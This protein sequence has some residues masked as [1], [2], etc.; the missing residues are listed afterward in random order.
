VFENAQSGRPVV[1]P[2]LP[3]DIDYSALA[4]EQLVEVA[5][6]AER[7]IAQ[8]HAVQSAA[9]VE[10]IRRFEAEAA[11]ARAAGRKPVPSNIEPWQEAASELGPACGWS[12][13]MAEHRV[14]LAEKL[15]RQLPGTLAA[16]HEGRIDL[17]RARAV[18]DATQGV[19]DETAAAVEQR[20]LPRAADQTTAQLRAALRRAVMAIDP[21]A[22]QRRH[23]DA[24]AKRRVEVRDLDDGI[25][26]LI[27]P[28]PADKAQAVYARV[29]DI[30]RQA[31]DNYRTAAGHLPD[32][33]AAR[34]AEPSLDSLRVDALL[35]LILG[36]PMPGITGS[37]TIGAPQPPPSPGRAHTGSEACGD[38][39]RRSDPSPR[40]SELPAGD[41]G[42]GR[43]CAHCG[44]TRPRPLLNLLMPLGTALGISDEPAELSGYGPIPA[45]LARQLAA[46]A[47]WRRIFT[48]P[49]S[50]TTTAAESKSYEPPASMAALVRARD[51]TCRFP[52]C[53]QPATRTDIDHR[54]PWP[55]GKTCPCN[56][57]CLCRFHH[58]LKTHH[59]WSYVLDPTSGTVTWLSPTRRAY[60]TNPES[61]PDGA[62]HPP[63]A[64]PE[65]PDLP[66][67]PQVG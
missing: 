4:P 57:C 54:L 42:C 40:T 17:N 31:L 49:V 50:G 23:D 63:P 55:H 44:C 9:A 8:A 5:A 58:Q 22:A 18:A 33:K 61:V 48:D 41:R 12:R 14:L 21:A 39:S 38:V 3:K 19:S 43:D 59:G 29:S 65:I 16:L 53:R 32:P 10:L 35:W 67:L 66:D 30:A 11:A 1:L 28:M 45:A 47:T 34:D 2:L 51:R 25:A 52:G 56:L 27:A 60:W 7:L 20:V 26:E 46:D 37:H 13:T 62:V 64:P 15:H 6:N 36:D 24:V